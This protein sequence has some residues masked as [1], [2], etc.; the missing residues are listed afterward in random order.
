MTSIILFIEKNFGK[1]F[2]ELEIHMVKISEW[3]L[4]NCLK[5]NATKFD[6][7]LSP[8]FDKSINVENF[9]IKSSYAEILLGVINNNN[10]SFSEHMTHL[11]ATDNRKL[12]ALSRASK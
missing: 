4:H 6:L 12:H 11:C 9:N 8:F 5:S 7:F 3:F 10:L 1:I 2:G